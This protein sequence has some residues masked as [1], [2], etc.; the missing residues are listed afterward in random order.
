MPSMAE[1]DSYG[2]GGVVG[3]PPPP[4]Q[5]GGMVQPPMDLGC[6]QCGKGG[7]P[8]LACDDPDV[9]KSYGGPPGHKPR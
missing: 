8:L 5:G 3:G 6:A 2:G 1:R 4:L 7:V 9:M